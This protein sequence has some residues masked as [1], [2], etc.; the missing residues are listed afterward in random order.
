MKK[1]FLVLY[2]LFITASC[3]AATY[4][5]A[6]AGNGGSDSNSGT[7]VSPWKTIAK[8]NTIESGH[9][10]SFKCGST[11]ND[12]QLNLKTGST[13]NS[14]D[15]GDKPVITRKKGV[16]VYSADGVN[17]FTIEGLAFVASGSGAKTYIAYF[18]NPYSCTIKKCDFTLNG[19]NYGIYMSS[20]SASQDCHDVNIIGCTFTD[21]K[22][23]DKT[24]AIRIDNSSKAVTISGCTFTNIGKFGIFYIVGTPALYD[25]GYR[26][27]DPAIKSCTFTGIAADAL[28]ISGGINITISGNILTDIGDAT[29]PNVNAMQINNCKGGNIQDN[30][31]D[32]VNTSASDGMGI[33]LDYAYRSTAYPCENITVRRNIIHGCKTHA[34]GGKAA[35]IDIFQSKNTK[36]YNNIIYDCRQGIRCFSA[37]TAGSVIYNNTMY[38]I[39]ECCIQIGSQYWEASRGDTPL[40]LIRNNIMDTAGTYGVYVEGI[41]TVLPTLTN[42]AYHAIADNKKICDNRKGIPVNVAL[43]SSPGTADVTSDP[44]FTDPSRA[45]FTLQSSSICRGA[46]YNLSS[47]FTDD[48][49]QTARVAWDIGAY[50]YISATLPNKNQTNLLSVYK[51]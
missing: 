18:K 29:F 11:F 51:N 45:E 13:Y 42:N 15:T 16:V 48:F 6:D 50:E 23:Y 26:H 31:I 28:E 10:I 14:Y 49:A 40:I 47:V 39:L 20:S 19:V 17:G 36:V 32:T 44:K 37:N 25:A 21:N 30:T 27:T 9:T 8:A 41:N 46:G 33:M 4:Y 5:F 1:L 35:G 22:S 43:N 38:N 34:K 12:A 24:E 7:Q 2:G 3:H